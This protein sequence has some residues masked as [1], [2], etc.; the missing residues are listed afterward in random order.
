VFGTVMGNK[1][2]RQ[3]QREKQQQCSCGV[4]TPPKAD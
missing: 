2:L 3:D 4:H 1:R